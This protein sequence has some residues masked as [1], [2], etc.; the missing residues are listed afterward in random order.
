MKRVTRGS[1][2][3]FIADTFIDRSGDAVTPDSVSF[4]I[5][6]A[7]ANRARTQDTLTATN[8][9][10]TEW[11]AD[12]D[13]SVAYPGTVYVSALANSDNDIVDDDQFQ[14]TANQAN[15]NPT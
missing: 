2:L 11:S 8:T 5:D 7:G 13:S 6:Y 1:T 12:W 10:G 9:S 15:P 14:L 3:T 4:R